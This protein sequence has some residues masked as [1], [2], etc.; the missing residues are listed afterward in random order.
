[1]FGSK[2]DTIKSKK[3]TEEA[4]D[5]QVGGE[6]CVVTGR[7]GVEDEYVKTMEEA[8]CLELAVVRS[9]ASS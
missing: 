2:E 4:V 1:M 6:G 7:K 8:R 9:E 3:T 5:G